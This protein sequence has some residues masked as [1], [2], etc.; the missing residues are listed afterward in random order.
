MFILNVIEI[1]S[2]WPCYT[3]TSAKCE[4]KLN[5]SVFFLGEFIEDRSHVIFMFA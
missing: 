4:N 1:L 5:K 2:S 3:N